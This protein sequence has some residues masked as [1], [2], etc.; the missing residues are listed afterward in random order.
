MRK[1]ARNPD[2]GMFSGRQPVLLVT[3]KVMINKKGWRNY[4]SPG[5]LRRH[6]DETP[7]GILE[8]KEGINRK[9]GKTQVVMLKD[10]V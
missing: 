6:G 5:S 3:V 10:G 9:N 4:H 7:C 2:P 8:Q 1:Y